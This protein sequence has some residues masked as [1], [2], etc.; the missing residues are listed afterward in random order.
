MIKG[1]SGGVGIN[2]MFGN[3]SLPY[4][5]QDT[6]NPM[7]GMIRIWGSDLQVFT[8]GSWQVISSSYATVDLNGDSASLLEWVRKKQAEEKELEAL[9]TD[10]PAVRIAKENLNKVKEEMA[11]AEAQLKAT[12]ILSKEHDTTS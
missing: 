3:T 10:H 1:L 4:V 6:T 9:S 2:V 11:R 7:Q 5:S 8:G 12:I